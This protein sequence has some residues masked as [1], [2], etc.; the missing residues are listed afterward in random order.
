MNHHRLYCC[1]RTCTRTRTSSVVKR[2]GENP[3]YVALDGYVVRPSIGKS[4]ET[5]VEVA[6][7]RHEATRN[8]CR[9]SRDWNYDE[10]AEV[11]TLLQT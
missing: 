10:V 1:Y 6:N 5:P 2:L 8:R 7:S 9:R 4:L 11:S 3:I